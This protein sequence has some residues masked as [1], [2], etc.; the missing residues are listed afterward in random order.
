MN[1]V[2]LALHQVIFN[3]ASLASASLPCPH[4]PAS[5]ASWSLVGPFGLDNACNGKRLFFNHGQM[6]ASPPPGAGRRLTSIKMFQHPVAVWH[7]A[8][9]AAGRPPASAYHFRGGSQLAVASA[10]LIAAFFAA[11]VLAQSAQPAGRRRA[12]PRCA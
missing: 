2:A 12:V 8:R 6:N 4:W 1:A 10:S 9:N 11:I 5:L 7:A 3:D